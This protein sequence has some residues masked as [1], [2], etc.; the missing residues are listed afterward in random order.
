MNTLVSLFWES[1]RS[2]RFL[3]ILVSLLG[4]LGV[5]LRRDSGHGDMHL[6]L[7][8]LP[9]YCWSGTLTLVALD[10]WWCLWYSSKCEEVC[11]EDSLVLIT[12]TAALYVWGMLLMSAILSTDFGLSLLLIVCIV[13]E[14]WLLARV[15][16]ERLY[17]KE[18]K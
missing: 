7:Q 13:I 12:C 1:T 16:A 10:R 4:A 11:A 15:F 8:T 14:F 2:V 5:Y 6:F 17:K 9:W 18:T 3:T